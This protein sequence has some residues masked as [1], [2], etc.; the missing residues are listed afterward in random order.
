[1]NFICSFCTGILIESKRHDEIY[2]KCNSCGSIVKK[3]AILAFLDQ[4]IINIFLDNSNVELSDFG[5]D[6]SYINLFFESIIKHI[7]N[8]ETKL[9]FHIVG[10]FIETILASDNIFI[11]G[12]GRSGLVG[13]GFI[14]KLVN[15]NLKSF[16]YGDIQSPTIKHDDCLIAL[17]GSG[18]TKSV[19]ESVESAKEKGCKILSLTNNLNSSLAKLSDVIWFIDGEEP[20]SDSDIEFEE[21]LITGEYIKLAPLGTLFELTSMFILD[22]FIG[23]LILVLGKT[24]DEIIKKRFNLYDQ[25]K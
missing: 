2:Y 17:S 7:E 15:L 11:Y 20:K 24:E 9:N 16:F 6:Y 25:Y 19:I 12:V 23:E 13:K 4:K 21:R 3:D 8:Y 10:E 5:S 14:E 22:S 18:E 1:M